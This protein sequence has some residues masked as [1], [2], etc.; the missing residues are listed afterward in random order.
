MVVLRNSPVRKAGLWPCQRLDPDTGNESEDDD[1]AIEDAVAAFEGAEF[2]EDAEDEQPDEADEDLLFLAAVADPA[3]KKRFFKTLP[4]HRFFRNGVSGCA[5]GDQCKFN[6]DVSNAE[7]QAKFA[8][9]KS[10]MEKR[11]GST[12]RNSTDRH[13]HRHSADTRVSRQVARR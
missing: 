10:T 3:E 4:C 7:M 2:E 11:V 9:A 12:A 13:H 5:L 6:H 8:Q 1:D